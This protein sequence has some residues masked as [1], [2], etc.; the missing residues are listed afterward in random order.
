MIYNSSGTDAVRRFD[1]LEN[2]IERMEAQAEVAVDSTRGKNLDN[3]FSKLE[4]D[5]KV[6]EELAALKKKMKGKPAQN[7]QAKPE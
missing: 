4:S 2:R 1:E 7:T 6:D 3:E 5:S